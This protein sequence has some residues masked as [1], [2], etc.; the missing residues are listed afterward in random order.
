[1]RGRGARAGAAGLAAVVDSA[2]TFDFVVAVRDRE[3]VE[4]DPP[5]PATATANATPNAATMR[6]RDADGEEV[7]VLGSDIAVR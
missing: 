3:A 2:A 5:H 4:L 6:I 1:M 7:A